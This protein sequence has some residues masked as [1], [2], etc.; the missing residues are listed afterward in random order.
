MN[1]SKKILLILTILSII[2]TCLPT[3]YA[4][5][6]PHAIWKYDD[7]YRTAVESGDL[8]GIITNGENAL[9]VIANEPENETI[10]SYR[11]SRMFEVAKA[12]EKLGQYQNSAKW[13]KQAIAPNI[14]MNFSDA[15]KICKLKSD[16]YTP[17]LNLYKETHSSQINYNA[18][19]EHETGVL[20]GVTSDSETRSEFHNESMTM[21]YHN[22]G[23]EFNKYMEGFLKEAQENN[24]AVELALNVT[25]EAAAIPY[26]KSQ[27]AWLD[28]FIDIL[29]KYNTIPIY[30][31]FA[32]EVN[33]WQNQPNAEEFKDAFR[34]V[35]DKIH[36]K[37]SH[38]AVVFGIN[39]VS[40][41]NGDFIKYYPGDEY[42]DWVGVSLYMNKN[43]LGNKAQSEE[44][45][46]NE[47]VFF[48]GEASEPVHILKPIMEIF[49][50]RKPIMIF[51]SGASHTTRS[52]GENSTEWAKKRVSEL[53]NYVPMVY[54]QIKIMGY[55]NT[56]M[57]DEKMDYALTTDNEL[58][59]YYK[60]IASEPHFI[61]NSCFNDNG[62]SY[63]DC[64][65]GFETDRTV[66]EFKVYAYDY[67][68]SYKSVSYFIDG[69][70]V[71]WSDT[72]PFTCK[73]DFKDYS[74]GNHTMTVK[75][76]SD[77]G[78]VLEK[79]VPFTVIDNIAIII[80]NEELT[81]LD[82]PP[83]IVNGRTM[84][85]VRAILEKLGANVE[86]NA[87]TKTVT[88][89]KDNT[90]LE[91][92]IGN[93]TITKNGTPYTYDVSAKIING[94][95]CIPARAASELLDMTVSWDGNTR[96]VYIN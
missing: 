17:E 80:N 32:G 40:D 23:D 58:R 3:A 2:T 83:V 88:A 75:M 81:G 34:F 8:Q 52:L 63:S 86:W 76:Y 47:L 27:E 7:M 35:A 92:V 74:T 31:R 87:E 79:T 14:A 66:N 51:E 15:V 5:T 82:Q 69:V 93:K 61:Q 49:G 73:I 11:A 44:E 16:L 4:Y 41:W 46:L 25:S 9:E 45:K 13:Y 37:S 60:S 1:K 85:P 78:T 30:L 70:Q 56:V 33:S 12:Y 6:F 68:S 42:V 22:Y 90:T 54:P 91:F 36:T 94:R 39:F 29:N 59:Q 57:S 96:T 43:F 48:A 64:K 65:Y 50:N 71:G 18:I 84:V 77:T 62:V 26:I 53:M 55:F 38:I 95:T 24:L 67:S 72:L 21:I 10:M 89:T 20:W 19:N 28:S